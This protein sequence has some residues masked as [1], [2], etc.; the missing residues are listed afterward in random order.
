M[1]PQVL[2]S[3]ISIILI[4]PCAINEKEIRFWSHCID[5]FT[6]N[7]DI[8]LTSFDSMP[9]T[10]PIVFGFIGT[11][12]FGK[13]IKVIA[14]NNLLPSCSKGF[15]SRSD[16]HKHWFTIMVDS[17]CSIQIRTWTKRKNVR[18]VKTSNS[19]RVFQVEN[20]LEGN[21]SEMESLQGCNSVFIK[22][23]V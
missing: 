10:I 11:Y 2:K 6:I 9:T 14:Q 15:I 22:K 16:R 7:T 4:N 23:N 19:A 5:V 3:I 20:Q 12:F 8:L 1:H 18:W 21:P 17:N 13:W